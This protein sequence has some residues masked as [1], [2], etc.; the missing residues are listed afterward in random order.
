M[1]FPLRTAAAAAALLAASLNLTTLAQA[2]PISDGGRPPPDA[3][4]E[5]LGRRL[6]GPPGSD[7]GDARPGPWEHA[8]GAW[9]EGGMAGP[10]HMPPWIQGLRL[11][12]A[13]QDQVFNVM[14]GREPALRDAFKAVHAAREA[15]RS[16]ALHASGDSELQPLSARVGQADAALAL[17]MAQ[18]DQQLLALLTPEQQK[19][20]NSWGEQHRR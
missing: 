19:Q 1:P 17:L 12:E 20:L 11:T 10:G 7:D 9:H 4:Q 18:T 6:P 5:R 2:D 16:A 8:H 14:Y 15:L 3:L 13:Q